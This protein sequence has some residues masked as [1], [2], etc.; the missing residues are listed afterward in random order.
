MNTYRVKHSGHKIPYLSINAN[1][2]ENAAVNYCKKFNIKKTEI[3]VRNAGY[4]VVNT[5]ENEYRKLILV[6]TKRDV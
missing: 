6:V 5:V 3:H 1:S 4:F 2:P